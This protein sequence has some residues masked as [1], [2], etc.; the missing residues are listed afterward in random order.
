MS[1]DA[2]ETHCPKCDFGRFEQNRGQLFS[3][4]IAHNRQ[5]VEVAI[6]Q[7]YSAL[8]QAGREQYSELEVIVGGG[9]INREIA[10][11]LEA[12]VWKGSIRSFRQE[13]LNR[14]AYILKL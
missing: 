6:Q 4:D 1:Y 14:G 10:V 12:E 8:V 5:T 3:V 9:L 11:I 2:S 7:L 13:P